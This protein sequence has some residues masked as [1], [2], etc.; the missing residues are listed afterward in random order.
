MEKKMRGDEGGFEGEF[1]GGFVGVVLL[2][3]EGVEAREAGEFFGGG[4]AAPG[5]E[6]EGGE[7]FAGRGVAGEEFGERGGELG[8][9]D[10]RGEVGDFEVLDK[11]ISLAEIGVGVFGIGEGI[12]ESGGEGVVA[13][14]E[15]GAEF[16]NARL[17]HEEG[18]GEYALF[19][20][21]RHVRGRED[22]ERVQRLF[23]E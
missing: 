22:V 16:V 18:E 20:K 8:D 3:G 9:D 13:G 21:G 23:V 19:R 10:G 7:E 11:E 12:G 5:T 1:E 2:A 4:G 14:G 17:R 15:R 6:G